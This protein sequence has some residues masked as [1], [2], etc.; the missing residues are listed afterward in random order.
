MDRESES[1]TPPQ[2]NRRRGEEI[3]VDLDTFAFEGK[4]IGRIDGLVVFVDGGVP[5]DRVRARLTKI[6]KQFLEADL[7]DLL[8][9]SSL[10]VD[11]RCRYFGLCGG[12]RWQHLDYEAQCAFKR[13]NVVDALERI[14]G[15]RGVDVAP[16]LPSSNVYF[17]RNK[18]EFSFDE[19][20]LSRE[21]FERR[22]SSGGGGKP[23]AIGLHV[24]GRFDKVLDIHECHL[25]SETSNRI[26]AAVREFCVREGLPAYS[27]RTHTGYLRNLVIR[28][29]RHSGEVMV[30]IVTA[31]DRPALM[32]RMCALLLD[33]CPSVSTF[34]NNITARKSGVAVGEREVVYHGPGTI[35][36]RIGS[37]LYRVSANSFFQTNTRQA[38]VLYE[39]AGSMADLTPT[40]TVWDLY[41]GTGSIALFIAGSVREVVGIEAVASAVEDA[42]QNAA[43]NGVTNCTFILGDLKEKLT[44]DTAWLAGHQR[45]DAMIVDPPRSGMH[46]KVVREIA[47]M[48]PDRLVYVSCNPATQARDLK[49][50]CG[51]APY[52]ITAVQPVDMF[53]HTY[54]IENVVGMKA[55]G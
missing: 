53:P 15:F 51:I 4:A 48:R 49:L 36:E 28:E 22:R 8:V 29:S 46:E 2:T 37:S 9:P 55:D 26:V 1:R 23:L 3:T 6:K 11:P 20:W 47:A 31:D 14:G 12:C 35:T 16:T 43:E 30:N 21:E 33:A 17:Y 44:Q 42:R 32:H 40:D 41:S 50:L 38:E 25:Q 18:M 54:H 34:I 10:R 45:P 24:P 39:T 19:E 5:G 7:V 52:K 13:Q 27:T